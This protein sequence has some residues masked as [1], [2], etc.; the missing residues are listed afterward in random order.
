MRILCKS[1]RLARLSAT[2]GCES[3]HGILCQA[4]TLTLLHR[5]FHFCWRIYWA[6]WWLNTSERINKLVVCVEAAA[7]G[8]ILI[9][10]FPS[11][12]SFAN[13]RYDAGL[14][15]RSYGVFH[16]VAV[17]GRKRISIVGIVYIL[18]NLDFMCKRIQLYEGTSEKTINQ[19][20]GELLGPW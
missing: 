19:R 18:W 20:W 1:I 11:A 10:N 13:I 5:N 14:H 4:D 17:N 9:Y 6:N 2:K 12:F 7:V 16:Q 3:G 8:W 15:T